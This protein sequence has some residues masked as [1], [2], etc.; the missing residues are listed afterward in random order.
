MP[1][2]AKRKGLSHKNKKPAAVLLSSGNNRSDRRSSLEFELGVP[3]VSFEEWKFWTL[4][5]RFTQPA[6]FD[7]LTKRLEITMRN[8]F[9]S[10]VASRLPDPAIFQFQSIIDQ[11]QIDEKDDEGKIVKKDFVTINYNATL[12]VTVKQI[13]ATPSARLNQ[14]YEFEPTPLFSEECS[15]PFNHQTIEEYTDELSALQPIEFKILRGEE[16]AVLEHDPDTKKINVTLPS[17]VTGAQTNLYTVEY[18]WKIKNEEWFSDASKY[19]KDKIA[20]KARKILVE[21]APDNIDETWIDPETLWSA[22]DLEENGSGGNQRALQQAN[23]DSYW[24]CANFGVGKTNFGQDL[25][26]RI[27]SI[28]AVYQN[29]KWDGQ[30]PTFLPLKGPSLPPGSMPPKI[31]AEPDKVGSINISARFLPPGPQW[32]D[33]GFKDR[34]GAGVKF[35][36]NKFGNLQK[37]KLGLITRIRKQR[38]DYYRVRF[39]ARHRYH[40]LVDG[41]KNISSKRSAIKPEH[42]ETLNLMHWRGFTVKAQL[43]SDYKSAAPHIRWAVP[44]FYSPDED[45]ETGGIIIQ[46]DEPIYSENTGHNL[47]ENYELEVLDYSPPDD[48]ASYPLIGHD[49]IVRGDVMNASLGKSPHIGDK[50]MLP[51]DIYRHSVGLSLNAEKLYPNTTG[52]A[53]I[54]KPHYKFKGE[55]IAIEPFTMAKIR[56]RR[57]P[58]KEGCSVSGAPA[59]TDRPIQEWSEPYWVQFPATLRQFCS[60]PGDLENLTLTSD[61][62][63]NH[64]NSRITSYN[65]L[66]NKW[67]NKEIRSENYNNIEFYIA[68]FRSGLEADKRTRQTQLLEVSKLSSDMSFNFSGDI[69]QDGFVKILLVQKR[70]GAAELPIDKSVNIDELFG[71]QQNP[72]DLK[73]FGPYRRVIAVSEAI[74]SVHFRD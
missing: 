23:S 12:I 56:I 71:F 53:F 46:M 50:V 52:S 34:G 31:I 73:E 36:E 4:A 24:V 28:D 74:K 42:K 27:G 45:V 57:A 32:E 65:T 7:A 63:I 16:K 8:Q 22:I 61:L 58:F 6:N 14:R 49:P 2:L 17:I 43:G 44:S 1:Y 41:V 10:M 33:V 25:F 55:E 3:G 66:E 72:E 30:P 47:A 9:S 20:G 21:V 26:S 67:E 38:A 60:A 48:K 5:E 62:R 18:Q 39:E 40:G 54:I 69:P 70:P 11:G 37:T 59:V 29:W 19:D 13:L 51:L 15:F 64:T 68:A 35:A